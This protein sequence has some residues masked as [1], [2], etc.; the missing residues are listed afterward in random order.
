MLVLV[1]MVEKN[2]LNVSRKLSR[3]NETVCI[4]CPFGVKRE[5]GQG[6]ARVEYK[7]D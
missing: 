4:D 3:L 5:L 2:F 6:E 7:T 1:K